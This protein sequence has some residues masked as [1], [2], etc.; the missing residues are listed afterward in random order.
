MSSRVP[1]PVPGVDVLSLPLSSMEGFI[2]SRVDGAATVEDIAMM[3]SVSVDRLLPVLDRLAD[4]GA[5]ELA[6]KAVSAAPSERP[7]SAP[8]ASD[9]TDPVAYYDNPPEPPQ[10][11]AKELSESSG[12]DRKL[13]RRILNAFYLLPGRT[14]YELLVIPEDADKAE[15]R[16]AYFELSKAFHPDAHFG[17]EL[18]GLRSKTE[19][20]FQRL[21]E[22]YETLSRKKRRDEYDKFLAAQ[23]PRRARRLKV[24]EAT[25]AALAAE[26]AK[27]AA[28]EAEKANRPP[29]Q[30]RPR[31]SLEE[32]RAQAAQRMRQRM[33]TMLP[34]ARALRQSDRVPETQVRGPEE[35]ERAREEALEGLRRALER[36]PTAVASRMEQLLDRALAAE[37]AGDFNNAVEM[38]EIVLKQVPDHADANE[39]WERV[40]TAASQHSV[41]ADREAAVAAE[42][43]GKW[44]SAARAW[45][46]VA[47]SEPGD[48][49]ANRHAAVSLLKAGGDLH[50]ARRYAEAAARIQPDNVANMV[51]LARVL[52]AAG[53]KL[54]ARRELE[55]AVKLKPQ[56]ETLKA[57][58][59][60]VR[61]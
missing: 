7:S 45:S 48:E 60:E 40:R 32:R 43:D 57:L 27:R 34:M 24:D 15:V 11:D 29:V 49:N 6:W 17:R 18:G 5:V 28:E 47:D 10:F 14:F 21:T 38:L 20:V 46:A 35:K 19:T 1:T 9:P 61:A 59:K 13:R 50:R 22:A 8:A 25:A 51:A 31:K 41:A 54:N 37:A 2:L 4:L 33:D 42:R 23:Y 44:R 36:S 16:A 53:L 3:V 39:A 52:L 58:L 55:K 56:D 26:E 30:V 12:I